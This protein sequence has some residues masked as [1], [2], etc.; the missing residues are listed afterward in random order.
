ML[1]AV[2]IT[3]CLLLAMTT[4]ALACGVPGAGGP[5]GVSLCNLKDR[6]AMQKPDRIGLRFAATFGQSDTNIV[7]PNGAVIGIERSA[8]TAS[9]E[10]RVRDDLV[11]TATGG[12][13]VRGSIQNAIFARVLPGPVLAL[14]L[15]WRIMGSK[16]SEPLILFT[17]TLSF[18]THPTEV[19]FGAREQYTATDVRL[20]LLVGKTFWDVFTPYAAVR[21]FGGPVFYRINGVPL[22]GGDQFHVQVGA[23]A[24]V[25]IARRVDLFLEGIPLGEKAI[26][27]GIGLSL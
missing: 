10:Y 8:T 3:L 27:A 21:L 11:L 24:S 25:S 2:A 5:A 6:K 23:G 17:T 14:S 7:F 4:A 1:R 16:P 20:G 9:A 13:V 26:T 15:S 12:V 22:V 19:A 18:V